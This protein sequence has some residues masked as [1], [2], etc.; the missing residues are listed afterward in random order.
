MQTMK[1]VSRQRLRQAALRSSC[2]GGAG[3]VC[4]DHEP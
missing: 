4:F 1:T 3:H 2:S